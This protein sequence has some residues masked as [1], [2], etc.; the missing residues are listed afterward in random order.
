MRAGYIE[1]SPEM[2]ALVMTEGWHADLKCVKGL[3]ETAKFLN[4][5]V[6]PTRGSLCLLFED[7]SFDPVP[8]GGCFPRLDKPMYEAH[9]PS[10]YD[11]F[12]KP[13][14]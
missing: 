11:Q 14:E 12:E 2:V 6:E 5:W 4:A 10:Y 7:E 3:P 13:E 9:F 8:E 1:V